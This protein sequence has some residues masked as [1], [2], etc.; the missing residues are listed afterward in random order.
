[1]AAAGVAGFGGARDGD[2][3]GAVGWV[4]AAA[5]LLLLANAQR[6]SAAVPFGALLDT[7]I[8][9]A[10]VWRALAIGAAG[11]ALLVAHAGPPR[12]RR[13]ALAA[14]GVAV[15]AAM[16]AHV[17]AGHAAAGGWPLRASVVTQWSHF[18]AVGV[19]LG[20]LAALLLAVQG[21]PSAAKAA[22]VRRF[23][24]IAAGGL[25]VV[26]VTGLLRAFD[27]LT[28]WRDLAS[29]GYGRAVVGKTVLLLGIAALGARNRRRSVPIAA[30]DLGPLRRIARSELEL[31]AC[32]LAVAALLGA[33]PPPAA[34]LR[35]LTG[36]EVSGADPGKTTQVRL[37]TASAEPGANRFV[38]R[39]TEYDS[40]DPV[41]A[42]R[43]SLR[44]TPLDDPG[45]AATS[46]ALVRNSNDTF[47]G[48]G[49]NL[50]FDGRWRVAVR[51]E[52]PGGLVE[53]PLE[54]ETRGPPQ[55]LSVRRT[56]GRPPEYTTEVALGSIRISP[57][58]E[59]AGPSNLTVT[60]FDKFGEERRV[61][62]LVLTAAAGDDPAR[63]HRVRRLSRGRFAA[64][65]DLEPGRNE[66]AAVA[67]I[68]DGTRM[69]AVLVLDVPG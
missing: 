26:A 63:Q 33:L 31:A 61:D 18:A 25:A 17:A 30:D 9:R 58:P 50:A 57:E 69:R 48:S 56:P 39:A 21:T 38:V 51:V 34:G 15:L 11:G 36:I 35:G 13:S 65:V 43:V 47:T 22:A 32:A 1:M 2:I 46:L 59:R 64:G 55:F 12:L 8:G 40:N 66:I 42:R 28:S 62:Q 45:V 68:E 44:F 41:P 27:E 29:T 53:I 6:L 24:R 3:L 67:H 10:L 52:R 14:C 54:L 60:V 7:S 49:A 20:G 19:W 5:G 16:A 4:V 23:S 37:T